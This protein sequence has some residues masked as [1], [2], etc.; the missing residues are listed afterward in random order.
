ML[1]SFDNYIAKGYG[2]GLFLFIIALSIFIISLIFNGLKGESEIEVKYNG[3]DIEDLLLGYGKNL[4]YDQK[5][6]RSFIRM[7]H[8]I[9][10]YPVI[11]N[12]INNCKTV[13]QMSYYCGKDKDGKMIMSIDQWKSIVLPYIN[14]AITWMRI[15]NPNLQIDN[16]KSGTLIKIPIVD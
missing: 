13:K 10:V 15:Y 6:F 8:S 7:P 1:Q 16:I 12:Q 5:R 11:C 14:I 9:E 2:F 4:S 3:G